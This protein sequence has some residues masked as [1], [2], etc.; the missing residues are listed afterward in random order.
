MAEKRIKELFNW[1]ENPFSFRIIPETFVGYERDIERLYQSIKDG[2]KFSLVIGP[3]G[4]GKTTL[5]KSIAKEFEKEYKYVIYLPKP[6]KY[7]EDWIVVFESV[8]KPRILGSLLFRKKNLNLYNL[9]DYVNKKLN[10]QKCLMFVDE[11]HESSQESLEWLRALTD[12]IDNL[13]V[14][15]AGLPVFESILKEKLESLMRRINTRIELTNLTKSETRELIKRRIEYSGG[16]DI[17]P[18]TSE[19]IEYIYEVTGGFPREVL[20]VCNELVR[21]AL[22]KNISTIDGEFVKE[23]QT[24]E[25]RVSLKTINALPER[26][27]TILKVLAEKGEMSPSEIVSSISIDEYKNRDNAIRSVN[28]LLRRLMAEGFVYRKRTGKTYKYAI[29]GKFHTMMVDD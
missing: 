18:F 9:S 21:K 8:I 16:D 11:C 28:N 17:K 2:E 3:T 23:M 26:Q 27:K 22:E 4:S 10:G 14:V 7:S 13:S 19:T 5:M 1:N 24:P 12:H 15:I 6:P 20:R 25:D 29:S